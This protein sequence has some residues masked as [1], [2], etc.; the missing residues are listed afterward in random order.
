[1]S[2]RIPQRSDIPEKDKWAIEDMYATDEAWEQDLARAKEMPEN[3]TVSRAT[4]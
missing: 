3:I 2:E 1:M 4:Y